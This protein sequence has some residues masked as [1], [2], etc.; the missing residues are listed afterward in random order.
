MSTYREEIQLIISQLQG[1]YDKAGYLRD[2]SDSEG[3]KAMNQ[4]RRSLPESWN[5]L[6]NLDGSIDEVIA[7]QE[8]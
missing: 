2:Q 7:N 5:I 6:Q 4:L 3:Q 8:V 1:I